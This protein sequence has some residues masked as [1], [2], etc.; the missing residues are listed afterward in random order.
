MPNDFDILLGQADLQC[1][2]IEKDVK[3]DNVVKVLSDA[4]LRLT[5]AQQLLTGMQVR[6]N[7]V[8]E[9]VNKV[10]DLV[11]KEAKKNDE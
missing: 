4:Q 6:I 11:H 5:E 7:A 8:Q 2:R 1:D 10:S 9:R 3:A